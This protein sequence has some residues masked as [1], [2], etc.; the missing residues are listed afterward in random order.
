MNRT[1]LFLAFIIVLQVQISTS[2][3]L[4]NDSTSTSTQDIRDTN[5]SES[6]GTNYQFVIGIFVVAGVV[7]SLIV[8]GIPLL[9]LCIMKKKSKRSR[10]RVKSSDPN[11][12]SG[13][14]VYTKNQILYDCPE[15]LGYNHFEEA[16]RTKWKKPIDKV[17]VHIDLPRLVRSMEVL[18]NGKKIWP[19]P[20]VN[21][22]D[23]KD[24]LV[25]SLLRALFYL[26]YSPEAMESM[27][28]LYLSYLKESDRHLDLSRRLQKFFL[29]CVGETKVS[30][31]LKGCN[32]ATIAPAVV[33]M[34]YLIGNHFPYSD[35]NGGWRIAIHIN[36]DEVRVK[37]V[38]W[39]KSY[40]VNSFTFKWE[41]ELIFD[42]DFTDLQAVDL[43]IVEVMFGGIDGEIRK[44][45]IRKSMQ[46]VGIWGNENY[47]TIWEMMVV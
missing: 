39:E 18:K 1:V 38:K 17:P 46:E 43:H 9:A 14:V 40:D 33:R 28:A 12:E 13:Y 41:Y 34:K 29:E 4:T 5:T 11:D 20:E 22:E 44:N 35:V 16:A 32:Q 45:Q 25:L 30:K 47:R 7:V 37:H 23:H 24:L 36:E 42:S 3:T 8:G 10:V 6:S 27:T 21:L 2:Q 15:D 31:L 26:L 19:S